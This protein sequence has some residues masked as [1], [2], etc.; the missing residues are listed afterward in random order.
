MKAIK[1]ANDYVLQDPVH[2]FQEYAEFKPLMNTLLNRKM[3]ERS[4]VYFSKDLR[5]VPRDWD[6][7]TQYAK[8][9]GVIDDDFQP[10][11]TNEFCSWE[12]EEDDIDPIQTQQQIAAI[13]RD[14]AS[15]GGVFAGK[16]N[17][18]IRAVA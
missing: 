17:R 6:K 9:L 15:H 8:R 18:P 16:V 7:V 4:F 3:F 10:N 5:C 2:A 11:Y 12:A 13:Q 1:A 14:I